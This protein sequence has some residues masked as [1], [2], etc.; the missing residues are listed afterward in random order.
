MKIPMEIQMM[1]SSVEDEIKRVLPGQSLL[2]IV[3]TPPP[4]KSALTFLRPLA[5]QTDD[6]RPLAGFEIHGEPLV[7]LATR[8]DEGSPDW[9]VL[10]IT[11]DGYQCWPPNTK[12]AVAVIGREPSQ[13]DAQNIFMDF[14]MRCPPY[15]RFHQ[16]LKECRKLP[17][18]GGEQ[19]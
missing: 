1:M 10:V 13:T 14:A 7:V 15:E 12:D 17:P 18:S 9:D 5:L 11:H 6:C 2:S 19:E 4:A 16:W 3:E 8:R